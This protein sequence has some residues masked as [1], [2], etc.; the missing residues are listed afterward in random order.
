MMAAIPWMQEGPF[1]VMV[2]WTWRTQ[3]RVAPGQPDWNRRVADFPV[4]R[5]VDGLCEAGAAWLIFTV[6]HCGDYFCAPNAALERYFPGHC[7]ERDLVADLSAALQARGRHLIVYFQTEI[8]HE[9]DAFREAFGWDLDRRDKS[10]FMERWR[11]VVST[12]ARGWGRAVDGWWFD[13]CYDMTGERHKRTSGWDNS[14]FDLPRWFA[15]ARAGNPEALVA[16]NMGVN[17]VRHEALTPLQD[18]LAGE[19]NTLAVRPEG[20]LQDGMQWHSLIWLDCPWGHFEQPGEI[21]GPRFPDEEL[22]EYLDDC[23]QHG[24]GV[25]FNVGVYQ[26]GSLAEGTMAQLGRL[27]K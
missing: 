15:A 9:S 3:P 10:V 7:S 20:P 2:H 13:S 8:D 24:G 17:D 21:C 4:E 5:F 18:Y 11:E 1:G 19:A 23:R 22:Q 25:T 27:R 6:G 14:R 12:Y 16:M 26:D